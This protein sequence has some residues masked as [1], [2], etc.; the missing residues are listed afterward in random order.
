M[1]AVLSTECSHSSR[2]PLPLPH[3][4]PPDCL[5]LKSGPPRPS[6]HMPL[7][8]ATPGPPLK[9][10]IQMLPSLTATPTLTALP[11]LSPLFHLETPRPSIPLHGLYCPF[12]VQLESPSPLLQQHWCLRLSLPH[13]R[14]TFMAPIQQNPIP[15]ETTCPPCSPC[16]WAPRGTLWI[17]MLKRPTLLGAPSFPT[18]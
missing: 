17:P 2:L 14:G 5:A 15:D 1:V 11:H 13:S 3:L 8:P 4:T 7:L 6:F 18:P 12:P 9:S 16:S 10:G